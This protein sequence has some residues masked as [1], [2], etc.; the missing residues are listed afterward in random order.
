[1]GIIDTFMRS[2]TKHSWMNSAEASLFKRMRDDGSLTFFRVKMCSATGC[3]NE[4][5]QSKR[6]CTKSCYNKQQNAG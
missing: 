5:H 3:T 4:V 1:M 2:A 6:Y